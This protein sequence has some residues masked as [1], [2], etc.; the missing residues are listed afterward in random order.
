MDKTLLPRNPKHT[1][2]N[3]SLSLQNSKLKTQNLTLILL[4][5][6]TACNVLTPAPTPS[7][8]P[9]PAP[10]ATPTTLAAAMPEGTP[11]PEPTPEPEALTIWT[12]ER[13][14]ALTLL[15]ELAAEFDAGSAAQVEVIPKSVAGL[16]ADLIAVELAAEPPPDLIWGDE[17]DLA[18][19]LA[20]GQLQPLDPVEDAAAFLP[21]TITSATA[22]GQIWGQPLAAQDFLLLF[23]NRSLLAEPPRTTDQLI[24]Q[25]RAIQAPGRA[26]IVAAW[27]E[28]LWLLPWINGFGDTPTT[29]DGSW[30]ALNT[31]AMVAALDLVRELRSAAPPDQQDYAQANA[32]F[33]AGEAALAIDGAWALPDYRNLQPA[34]N[35]AVAPLP[36]VPATNRLAAPALGGTYLMFHRSLDGEELAQG[37][38]FARFL[39]Q[40]EVQLRIASN[41][42]RLPALRSSLTAPA[43]SGDAVLA[44]AAAQAEEAIGLPPTLAL[45][46]ALSGINVQLPAFLSEQIDQQGAAAAMQQF[47]EACMA[48]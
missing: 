18:G 26:G 37:Q 16:R 7:P 43:I 5:F 20:D 14:A 30:P 1:T 15:L 6:L 13:D 11:T 39:V 27:N 40:P 33:S 23:Y 29:P 25:S 24:I 41:L 34:V 22:E 42:Q 17:E 32:R 28:A 31:P 48:E 12:T 47:A 4:F 8:S 2:H 10:T 36:R 35:F 38:D 46:C 45:R 19:L 44:A 21:A 3:S 9:L